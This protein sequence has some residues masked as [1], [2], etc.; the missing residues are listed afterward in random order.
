MSRGF[1]SI[2][3]F[4]CVLVRSSLCKWHAMEYNLSFHFQF[5][6]MIFWSPTTFQYVYP[7]YCF[8]FYKYTN[9]AEAQITFKSINLIMLF[10]CLIFFS[11]FSFFIL[12]TLT[13]SFWS[14]LYFLFCSLHMVFSPLLGISLNFVS[15]DKASTTVTINQWSKF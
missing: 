14:L 13:S 6:S 11:D 10:N 8:L 15:S 1:T 5:R 2:L 4:I 7:V 12:A 9:Y 3:L